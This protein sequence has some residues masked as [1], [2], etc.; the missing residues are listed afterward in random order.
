MRLQRAIVLDMLAHDGPLTAREMSARIQEVSPQTVSALVYR[1]KIERLIYISTW[2]PEG[3]V[4]LKPMPA[5]SL[6]SEADALRPPRARDVKQ[7]QRA[8][9]RFIKRLPPN[10][11][12]ALAGAPLALAA[13]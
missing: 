7:A 2:K 1:L 10:S 3:C 8:R 6:G 13:T 12:W 4:R 9:Q 11:V 5:Y